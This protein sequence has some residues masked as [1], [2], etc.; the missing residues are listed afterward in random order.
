MPKRVLRNGTVLLTW[1]F[2]WRNMV[3]SVD[4]VDVGFIDGRAELKA[5]KEFEPSPGEKLR[6]QLV[7]KGFVTELQATWNGEPLDGSD[8]HPASRIGAA[9][10]V[11]YFLGGMNLLMALVALASGS[12]ALL[13]MGYGVYNFVLACIYLPAAY[14]LSR[15]SIVALSLVIAVFLGD[16]VMTLLQSIRLGQPPTWIIVRIILFMPLARAIS[17]F[18]R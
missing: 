2:P 10:G 16:S 5:G 3:V 8:S 18:R 11:A 13:G 1:K 17:A 6:I 4:G 12:Q 15:R 9:S 7:Q 14:F